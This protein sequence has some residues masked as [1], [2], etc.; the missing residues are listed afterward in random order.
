MKN[1]VYTFY[2]TWNKLVPLWLCLRWRH[3]VW[4]VHTCRYLNTCCLLMG[5]L[6]HI[7]VP[8][9]TNER[10]IIFL[11]LGIF[12]IEAIRIFHRSMTFLC[13]CFKVCFIYY[14]GKKV[15]SWFMVDWRTGAKEDLLNSETSNKICPLMDRNSMFIGRTGKF[16]IN[17]IN[18]IWEWNYSL[19]ICTM[20]S[21]SFIFY[22]IFSLIFHVILQFSNDLF[23]IRSY[24]PYWRKWYR[25]F[26]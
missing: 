9:S 7:K 20:I 11:A 1:I 26:V 3:L 5:V 15:D 12:G 16:A 18:F 2:S 10:M 13:L 6:K 4:W 21:Y 14:S 19:C 24:E 22:R 8:S 17:N 23:I 25:P